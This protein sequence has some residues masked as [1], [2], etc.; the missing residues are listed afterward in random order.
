MRVIQPSSFMRD[1]FDVIGKASDSTDVTVNGQ[2]ATRRD[3]YFHVEIEIQTGSGAS[4]TPY[5]VDATNSSGTTTRNGGKFLPATPENFIYDFDGNLTSDGRFIYT[6]DAENRLIGMQTHASVPIAARRKLAF[7]YDS[8]G[9]RIRKTVMH[10]STNGGWQHHHQIDFIYDLNGWNLL[11][12]RSSG[13]ANAFLRTYTWGTDLGGQGG[14]P[15]RGM[16]S[17]GLSAIASATAGGVGGLL[18]TTFHL[19]NTTLASGMDLNGNV[20]LLINTATSQ[21]AAI[22]DYGPFGE[23]IRQSGEYATLNPFRFSTKYTDNETGLLYYGYR[24]YDPVT[25]RWPSRDPIQERGGVN[26][27]GMVGNDGVNRWDILGLAPPGKGCP[28][29]QKKPR[30]PVEKGEVI[31]P[32]KPPGAPG[33]HHY[34]NWGGPGWAN[35]GWNAEDGLLP[36][37]DESL[38]PKDDRD[39]CYKDH[40]YE[41]A[42]CITGKDCPCPEDKKKVSDCI[43]KADHKLANCLRDAGVRGLEPWAFDT[44]IPWLVH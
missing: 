14:S 29:P 26:L 16:Q 6:W 44:V 24:Y 35:G 12:E 40:D 11:A 32:P 5:R 33:F 4:H 25:G 22:Y 7:A 43:E 3:E 10:P 17:A 21:P 9:R 34:G 37:Y 15:S 27:Y 2:L 42:D 38:A 36:P 1:V 13:R 39:R 23:P 18:F 31:A 8:M 30:P 41:I 28:K 20:T 19:S